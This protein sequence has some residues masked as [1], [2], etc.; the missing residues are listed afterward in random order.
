MLIGWKLLAITDLFK[1][2]RFVRQCGQSCDRIGNW[3]MKTVV[4]VGGPVAW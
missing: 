2:G 4:L 3:L 1:V